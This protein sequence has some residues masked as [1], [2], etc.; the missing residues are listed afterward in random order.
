MLLKSCYK[1]ENTEEDIESKELIQNKGVKKYPIVSDILPESIQSNEELSN[2]NEIKEKFTFEACESIYG[3]NNPRCNSG[4]ELSH[5]GYYSSK[6]T[7]FP[8]LK[9]ENDK[10]KKYIMDGKKIVP[11]NQKFW[12]KVFYFDEPFKYKDDVPYSFVYNFYFIGKLNNFHINK[13][14]FVFEKKVEYN[15]YKYILFEKVDGAFVFAY[16]LPFRTKI[17]PGDVVF[18]KNN[19]ST[20]GPFIFN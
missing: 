18:I 6:N 19:S 13:T 4:E 15:L 7:K 20:F 2:K 1:T 17:N 5:I 14:F 12:D 8:V 9:F 11:F 3:V 16:G 10:K